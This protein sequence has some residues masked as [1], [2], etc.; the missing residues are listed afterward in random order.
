[1]Q[2]L[3]A[4]ACSNKSRTCEEISK[5]FRRLS[6][7]KNK[8]TACSEAPIYLFNNSGPF[9]LIKFNP[10]SEATALAIRVF[11]QPGGPYSN[12]LLW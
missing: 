9:T 10:H 3:A 5:E 1:M 12:I 2:G 11:P 6:K 4:A 8:N 7:M